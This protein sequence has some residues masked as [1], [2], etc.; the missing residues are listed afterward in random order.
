MTSA[1]LEDTAS[2]Q[3]LWPR[4][5]G[6]LA[7][8]PPNAYAVRFAVAV[9]LAI[10][11]GKSSGLV[12]N[13]PNWI[14]ITVAFVALPTTGSSLAKG[15][16]RAIGTVA[17][18]FTAIA[19]YGLFAQQPPLL[20]V[21]FFL[22]QAIAC[23][24]YT[25]S[26]GQY[27]WFVW[28]FTTAIVL[29]NAMSSTTE[30]VEVV[31]FQRACMV[32]IGIG[33]VTA[34]DLV[35]W[36]VRAETA[37]RAALAGRVEELRQALA[38]HAR[39]SDDTSASLRPSAGLQQGLQLVDALR[40]EWMTAPSVV[41]ALARLPLLLES[42]ASSARALVGSRDAAAREDSRTEEDTLFDRI[43][44][45]MAE[46]AAALREARPSAPLAD[47]LRSALLA[48]E[49]ATSRPLRPDAGY[50][51]REGRLAILR[52]LV[53]TLVEALR[54][55]SMEFAAPAVA[56]G[57]PASPGLR[58]DPFRMKTAMRVGAATVAI[59][60]AVMVLD[61]PTNSLVVP[62]AFLAAVPTRGGANRLALSFSIT[63][64]IAWLVADLLLVFVMPYLDR[65]PLALV[66]AFLCAVG[67]AKLSV[68]RPV[69]ALLPSLGSVLVMLSV[70]GGPRA[71]TDVYGSYNTVCYLALAIAVGFGLA[72]SLWPATAATLF[73][74]RIALQLQSCAGALKDAPATSEWVQGIAPQ[75]IQTAAL[76]GQAS[77]EP[78]E[79]G[80]DAALRARIQALV[81][82]LADAI[83]RERPQAFDAARARSA[84]RWTP[85]CDAL[86]REKNALLESLQRAARALGG[87]DEAPS[88]ALVDARTEVEQRLASLR[89]TASEP[90]LSASERQDL[91]RALD[92]RRRISSRQQAIEEWLADWQQA[93]TPGRG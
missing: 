78:L 82:D 69:L 61:W 38:A 4:V 52:E 18:A 42:L 63:V 41:A 44:S 75:S 26:R 29:W 36:P 60:L 40:A 92:A 70:Y 72:R 43:D 80:L 89:A 45:G 7:L 17:G 28:A 86:D 22:V 71:P 90:V 32:L 93:R 47:P 12:D 8:A 25:G 85:L 81:L 31:A 62:T 10:W 23:Y 5:R 77:A 6:W 55:L 16:L 87:A 79:Q 49:A 9:T 64:A 37:L 59:V 24:G 15:I 50:E 56:Q 54:T 11:I 68:G 51:A 13:N 84:E 21:G 33:L 91:L 83:P 14:V 53:T 66:P 73:R 48:C 35:F 1:A 76:D 34:C 39:G 2:E 19:L 65:A 57:S 27:A 3:P 20:M 58:L 74:K 88:S 30:T 46:L 67:F